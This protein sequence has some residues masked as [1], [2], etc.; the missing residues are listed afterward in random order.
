MLYND[1]YTKSG[2]YAARDFI[3]LHVISCV[4]VK[5][6]DSDA[7]ETEIVKTHTEIYRGGKL[8]VPT[9]I[10]HQKALCLKNSYSTTFYPNKCIH[11]HNIFL[12]YRQVCTIYITNKMHNCKTQEWAKL[13]KRLTRKI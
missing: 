3:V 7:F 13:L 9:R 5:I 8:Y 11:I 2:V 10:F 1:N 6:F 12:Y 4:Y